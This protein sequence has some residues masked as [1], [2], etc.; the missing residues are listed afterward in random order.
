[1]TSLAFEVHN[2]TVPAAVVMWKKNDKS[3]RLYAAL[4]SS[5]DLSTFQPGAWSIVVF[6]NLAGG[7]VSGDGSGMPKP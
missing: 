3:K 7:T 6:Y 1:M 5:L 2:D 4:L